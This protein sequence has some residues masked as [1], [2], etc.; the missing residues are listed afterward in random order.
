MD[1]SVD[2]TPTT[3]DLE[4]GTVEQDKVSGQ[5]KE[6]IDLLERWD[7]APGQETI[8]RAPS[9]HFGYG[10]SSKRHVD[11]VASNKMLSKQQWWQ[12]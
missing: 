3:D 1:G 11:W 10:N 5:P 12:S 2:L 8:K 9:S 6:H 7:V 4:L